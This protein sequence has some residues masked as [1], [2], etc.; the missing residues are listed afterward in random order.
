MIAADVFL[1]A[2]TRH[3]FGLYTGVPCSYLKPFIN[4]VIDSDQL[5]YVGAANEGDVVA[6]GAGAELAGKRSVVMFQNS[7]LGN[8]VNP[9]T[10]LTCP[11]KIPVLLIPTLRGE[12]GGAPDEPQH[13][14]MGAITTDMLDL[15]QIP[16]IANN[17]RLRKALQ[18]ITPVMNVS[19]LGTDGDFLVVSLRATPSGLPRALSAARN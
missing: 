6:I 9:L 11:F 4:S 13:E 16:K 19:A 18:R 1:E 8:T 14:L 2:S 15:M 3:G 7:G 17:F 10:S 12:P 5:R